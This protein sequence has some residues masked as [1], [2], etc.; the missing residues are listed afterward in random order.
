MSKLLEQINKGKKPHSIHEITELKYG[1]GLPERDREKGSIPVFGSSGIVGH[2][3][4]TKVNKPAIIIGR[5]GNVGTLFYSETPSYPIDT[6]YFIDK[7]NEGFDLKYV[8]Y[9][10]NKINLPR[11][12]GDSAVPG[13]SR[14]TVYSIEVETSDLP[15][16][17]K[18]A[19]ILSAYDAKIE[20][21]NKEIKWLEE[22]AQITF[23]EWFV[24]FRFLGWDKFKFVDSEMGEIPEGWKVGHIK[25]LV[26]V[27]SGFPFSSSIFNNFGKYKLVT[28]RNVQDGSFTPD[29]D[30]RIGELPD[31]LP[32]HCLLGSGD[33]LLSLTGN[34]GRVCLVNG[35]NYVLNQRVSVLIPIQERDRAYTY[36]LFRKSDFQNH[37]ISISKGTAQLNLSPVETKELEM[38]VPDEE[39]LE[40]YSEVAM[41]MYKKIVEINYENQKLKQSRDQ[42]LLKLI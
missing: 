33:I 34:V 12:N 5:K 1:F 35:E 19:E 13:L 15:T 16:Q 4:E 2:H 38:V 20:N 42:L 36:F 3:S 26:R 10:L 17:K 32:K 14:D 24:A 25:D 22:L 39:A 18:I 8:Y 37:L 23:N 31:K 6:V 28:I 41:P 21:N 27:E 11:Y 40:R 29:C 30:N 7:P 9:L